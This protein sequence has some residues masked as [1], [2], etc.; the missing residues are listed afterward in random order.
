MRPNS[1]SPADRRS[2]ATAGH[3]ARVRPHATALTGGRW[4]VHASRTGDLSGDLA[5]SLD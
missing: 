4:H 3:G 5:V 2:Y 1:R